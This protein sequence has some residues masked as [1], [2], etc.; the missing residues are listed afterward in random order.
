MID[1]HSHSTASD[2][3]RTP[4]SLVE[5]ALQG[6][7]TA[8]ALTDHDT[9]DGVDRAMARARDTRLTLIPG[10]EIEIEME[11]GEFHLLGL[12]LVGDRTELNA[13]L[14]RL[15][16]ARSERNGRMVEKMRKAGIDISLE[17]L[18]GTA[19]GSIVSRAHF[20]RLLVRKKVVSSIDAAFK[21]LIGKGREFYEPRLCLALEEA[22]R[23]IRSA[24]GVAVVAHPV[25]LGIKGPALRTHLAACRDRGVA[26]IE[27]W[28]PNHAVKDCHRFEKLAR[29]LGMIVT[30]G[31]DYHGD[32]V[33]GRK[34]GHT[35]GGREIPDAILESLP[36]LHPPGR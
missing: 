2:G 27:A 20:A 13:S 31:S 14:G 23:L 1:L 29:G 22:T 11:G 33:P 15:Q 28:H 24:G 10:V 7:L 5:L 34:L 26:G 30:G 21:R 32:H 36:A 25:S 6:G 9:L 18:A 12:A 8:L 19:G 17:E 3:S 4:E 16:A 35:A